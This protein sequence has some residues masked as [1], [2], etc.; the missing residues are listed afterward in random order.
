MLINL[1]PDFFAVLEAA[2]PYVW[3]EGENP[4]HANVTV[5]PS[6]PGHREFLSGGSWISY[7]E[8]GLHLC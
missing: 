7:T 6:S 3:I 1:L 8:H 4:T 5:P 2:D